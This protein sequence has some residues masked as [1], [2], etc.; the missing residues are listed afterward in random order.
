MKDAFESWRVFLEEQKE[1]STS[2][3]EA[4]KAAAK[5]DKDPVD[6]DKEPVDKDKKPAAPKRKPLPGDPGYKG[7][8][9]TLK[10][11][12]A[13]QKAAASHRAQ[14]ARDAAGTPTGPEYARPGYPAGMKIVEPGIR[15]GKNLLDPDVAAPT[16]PGGVGPM[17][18]RLPSGEF[19]SGWSTAGVEFDP[20]VAQ[21]AKDWATGRVIKQVVDRLTK[22][23]P[24]AED[25]KAALA[26]TK[27]DEPRQPS[28]ADMITADARE[29][30]AAL[31]ARIKAAKGPEAEPLLKLVGTGGEGGFQAPVGKKPMRKVKPL[32]LGDKGKTPKER[33]IE[34]SRA[35]ADGSRTVAAAKRRMAR[36]AEQF[37]KQR[38]KE[39]AP[40]AKVKEKTKRPKTEKEAQTAASQAAAKKGLTG[41]DRA[42]FMSLRMLDW[43]EKE[44]KA[45]APVKEKL[46]RDIIDNV[47]N[48]FLD[49]E[50]KK[51]IGDP[52]YIQS[53]YEITIKV[54]I[55]KTR[56]G[57][58][59]QTFTE[60]RGIPGV[61]VVTVDPVGT[62]RD[63]TSYYSTLNC[64][65][66]LVANES[67]Q[68]YLKLVLFPGIRDIKGLT[69]R[70]AGQI[71]PLN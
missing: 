26:G 63:E 64:K 4:P 39:G 52:S 9:H 31:A 30:D 17:A 25:V 58:R 57:D 40:K 66:E 27:A 1:E 33:A 48:E 8:T 69:L 34:R 22:K 50:P 61:T 42:R 37:K 67:P 53:I 21:Q 20:A 46:I 49:K 65:F 6:K 54:S 47:L 32:D 11:M 19:A 36:D 2:A 29:R 3:E 56:G 59:E 5:T 10:P 68:E 41:P 38:A 70:H 13:A 28:A 12:T 43:Y 18:L 16:V 35:R 62:S 55:H 23:G 45:K 24:S 51:R 60:I 71:R 14:K 15:V 7:K 44:D